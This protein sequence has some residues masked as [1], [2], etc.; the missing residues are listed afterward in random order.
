MKKATQARGE[1]AP[2]RSLR[3][4]WEKVQDIEIAL[5]VTMGPDGQ[6][7]ARPMATQALEATDCLWFFAA[8]GSG[9]VDAIR[10]NPEVLLA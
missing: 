2:S 7:E 6:L 3:Q 1:E 5:L 4:L 10:Q 8:K 9:K